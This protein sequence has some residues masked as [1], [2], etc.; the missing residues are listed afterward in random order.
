MEIGEGREGSGEESGEESGEGSGEGSGERNEK[1]VEK[2]ME[3][4][5]ENDW[6]RDGE[7]FLLVEDAKEWRRWWG[8]DTEN[9]K[10]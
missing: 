3:K 2:G 1:G 8:G 9:K 7:G 4:G 6:R 10:F 5:D